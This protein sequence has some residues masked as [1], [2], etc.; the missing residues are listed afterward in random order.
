MNF[1][2]NPYKSYQ[3][4]LTPNERVCFSVNRSGQGCFKDFLA[5]FINLETGRGG[6]GGTNLDSTTVLCIEKLAPNLKHYDS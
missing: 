2:Q 1:E 6:E 4:Y 3:K 5:V